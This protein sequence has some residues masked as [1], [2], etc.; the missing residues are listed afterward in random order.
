MF[1]VKITGREDVQGDV[2]MVKWFKSEGDTVQAGEEIGEVETDKADIMLVAGI[3]GRIG[4]ILVQEG[5]IANKSSIF[6]ILTY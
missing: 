5:E 2:V 6:C 3:D 1:E 4:E